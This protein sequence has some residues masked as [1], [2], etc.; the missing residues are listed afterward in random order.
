MTAQRRA[1]LLGLA[2]VLLWSTVAAAFKL[3]LRTLSPTQLLLY[4]TATALLILALLMIGRGE[5]GA[6]RTAP[7]RQIRGALLL[8]LLNPA[9]Y[10]SVLF[11]AY[12]RLPAQVAQPLNYTWAITLGALSIPLLGQRFRPRLLL[13]GLVAYSGVV[14]IAIQGGEGDA[15]DPFGVALALGSTLLWAL[16]WIG[17]TKNKLP[18]MAG[19]FLNF[20]AALP[21]VF[22]VCLFTDGLVPADL[23]GLWGAL[24]V[25]AVEMAFAF[26]LWLT[27]LKLADS[28]A[29]IA[30]LI[31]FAPFISLVFIATVAD[32]PIRAGTML[33]LVLI[34]G[35]LLIQARDRA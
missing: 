17:N 7:R 12:D 3:S 29:R 35:G 21:V 10:Y 13:A 2:A 5:A 16:Y 25:G 6:L 4:A 27:A 18:P 11:E 23:R 22:L 8:G 32:E 33:G 28:A 19:L 31:F 15:A 30:N 24:Y 26:A 9:L 1:V 34:V 20:A 14:L